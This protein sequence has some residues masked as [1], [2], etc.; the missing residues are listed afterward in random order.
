M[1]PGSGKRRASSKLRDGVGASS[2][3][4]RIAR[5][6]SAAGAGKFSKKCSRTFEYT[7]MYGPSRDRCLWYSATRMRLFY[8]PAILLLFSPAA[9]FSQAGGIR[10]T[11]LDSTDTPIAGATVTLKD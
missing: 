4:S 2:E 11:V 8:L 6:G 1:P 10:G 5:S 9:V 3:V 7:E